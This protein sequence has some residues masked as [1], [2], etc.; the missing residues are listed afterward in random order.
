M[1]LSKGFISIETFEKE[2]LTKNSPI[3]AQISAGISRYCRP[4]FKSL[5]LDPDLALLGVRIKQGDFAIINDKAQYLL[6][7]LPTENIKKLAM[8]VVG[9]LTAPIKFKNT[10]SEYPKKFA[11][12]ITFEGAVEYLADVLG[13]NPLIARLVAFDEKAY[14]YIEKN[15]NFP[16]AAVKK[17]LF[18]PE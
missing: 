15:Y 1:S 9:V 10:L 3:R 16:K 8:G 12:N 7:F 13:I 18:F 5:N 4:L 14:D 2:E 17:T 6:P 11:Y